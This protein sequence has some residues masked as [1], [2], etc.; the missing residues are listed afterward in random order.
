VLRQG[1][2]DAAIAAHLIRQLEE[3]G[4]LDTRSAADLGQQVA[5]DR[6]NPSGNE[7]LGA[8]LRDAEHAVA[9]FV[10]PTSRTQS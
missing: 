4:R 6:N 10:L 2:A 3:L 9:A 1:S 7:I 8:L 5:D